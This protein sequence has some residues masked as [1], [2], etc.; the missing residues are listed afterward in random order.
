M[1]EFVQSTKSSNSCSQLTS[2]DANNNNNNSNN[3]D[4]N[5]T[6][7]NNNNALAVVQK[8]T[9]KS[10]EAPQYNITPA[11]KGFIGEASLKLVFDG[12]LGR[13][14]IAEECYAKTEAELRLQL[15]EALATQLSDLLELDAIISG[16]KYPT[17]SPPLSFSTPP[18]TASPSR[19]LALPSPSHPSPYAY[20]GNV[21]LPLRPS[22]ALVPSK[23]P[24]S[25]SQS[26]RAPVSKQLARVDSLIKTSGKTAVSLLFEWCQQTKRPNPT[27]DCNSVGP[28][29]CTVTIG[30]LTY[31]GP[32]CSSKQDAK[33]EAAKHVLASLT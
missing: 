5:N 13:T 16:N 7:N 6:P 19:P 33:H 30:N 14:I 21:A 23:P 20:L 1:F 4:N 18:Y 11:G 17:S 9:N 31:N 12:K 25:P 10:G 24:P 8:Y 28:F 2:Y 29:V 22:S 26:I 15:T 3:N 27:T 32:P